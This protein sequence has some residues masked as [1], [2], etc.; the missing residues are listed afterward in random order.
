MRSTLMCSEQRSWLYHDSLH[1]TVAP[2][3]PVQSGVSV[4]FLK[5]AFW[6]SGLADSGDCRQMKAEMIRAILL[7]LEKSDSVCSNA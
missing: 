4:F 7:S 2:N 6:L 1:L 3:Y 5:K